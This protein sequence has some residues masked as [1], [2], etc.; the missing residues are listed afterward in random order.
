MFVKRLIHST[1]IP[2]AG[3][4]ACL[5]RFYPRG[6]SCLPALHANGEEAQRLRRS[7]RGSEKRAASRGSTFLPHSVAR[8]TGLQID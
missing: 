4:G 2:A 6:F 1:E 3:E 5:H 7:V 8:E